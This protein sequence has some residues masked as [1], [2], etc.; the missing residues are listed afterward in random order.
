MNTKSKPA[1]LVPKARESAED[2]DRFPTRGRGVLCLGK[3]HQCTHAP[4]HQPSR[5]PC[6]LG[7]VVGIL[8][9]S[10]QGSWLRESRTGRYAPPKAK[11]T[12]TRPPKEG[13]SA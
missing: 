5:G 4:T 6:S 9:S 10:S 11:C 3:R 1:P 7:I 8:G 2:E 13:K 12:K